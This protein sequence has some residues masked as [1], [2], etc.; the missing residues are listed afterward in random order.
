MALPGKRHRLPRC[1]RSNRRRPAR[2]VLFREEAPF[3]GWQERV[4]GGTRRLAVG[5]LA[6]G[7]SYLGNHGSALRGCR[8]FGGAERSQGWLANSSKRE[9]PPVDG[10]TRTPLPC[11]DRALPLSAECAKIRW[12]LPSLASCLSPSRGPW[13]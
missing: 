9:R 7:W 4:C 5:F 6:A 3:A 8:G 1:A 2:V 12:L 13:P 10:G 11:W